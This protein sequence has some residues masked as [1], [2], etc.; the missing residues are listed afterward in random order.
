MTSEEVSV[1]TVVK[2]KMLSFITIRFLEP[3]SEGRDK[4]D[5]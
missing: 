1:D 3:R 2:E 5:V 4:M